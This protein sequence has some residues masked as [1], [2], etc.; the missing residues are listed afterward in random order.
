[1]HRGDRHAGAPRHAATRRPTRPGRGPGR[2]AAARPRVREGTGE[3]VD[4]VGVEVGE[5]DGVQVS[6]PSRRGSGRPGGSGPASTST[7]RRGPVPAPGRRP[8]RRRTR[9]PPPVGR[10][11]D[12][13]VRDQRGGDEQGDTDGGTGGP[14]PRRRARGRRAAR[15]P[16]ARP[17]PARLPDCR[18]GQLPPGS[19][20]KR[21][22]TC[23]ITA[24]GPRPTRPGSPA[25]PHEEV[26]A[27]ATPA[28]WPAGRAVRRAG[29]P[30]R[31]RG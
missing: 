20:A 24:A 26:R 25:S 7:A 22:A 29:W 9:R 1:M 11:G 28:R 15:R 3:P 30:G 23:A 27:A 16:R 17:G 6:T 2:R 31:R 21:R 18:P 19:S 13:R 14:R 5:H 8:G 4:M 10:P 12:P